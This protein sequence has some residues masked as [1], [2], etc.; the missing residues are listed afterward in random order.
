MQMIA[1]FRVGGPTLRRL[2]SISVFLPNRQPLS[3]FRA[4][5]NSGW[6]LFLLDSD[7]TEMGH[8]PFTGSSTLAP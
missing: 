7:E 1:A 6:V 3:R 4:T 8:D 5:T 2:S